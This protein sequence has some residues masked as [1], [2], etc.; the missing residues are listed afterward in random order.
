M[1]AKIAEISNSANPVNCRVE[2]LKLTGFRNY[3]SL[4]LTL[5]ARPIVLTGRN[6]AGKTNLLEAVSFL[7]DGRGLRRAGYQ[8]IIQHPVGTNTE[9]TAL[10][11]SAGWAVWG[12]LTG[13]NGQ[14][15]IGTGSGSFAPDAGENRRTVRIDGVTARSLNELADYSRIIWL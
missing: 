1:T 9:N 15:E 3:K 2:A 13:P 5:D 12:R 8:E 4:S 14:V 7:C 6:G 10:S 11:G